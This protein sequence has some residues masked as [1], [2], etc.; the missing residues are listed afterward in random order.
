MVGLVV[1]LR[2]RIWSRLV[3]RNTGLLVATIMGV[4]FGLAMT[5]LAAGLLLALR[6]TALELRAAAVMAFAMLTFGWTALSVLSGAADSTV[7]P[8]RFALLPVRPRELARGLLAATLTGVP[9]A[10]LL[11][12]ALT[13]VITWSQSIGS[14]AAALVAA[15]LGVLT[16]VLLARVVSGALG[17]IMRSRR[18]RMA[19]ALAITVIAILPAMGGLYAGRPGATA[20]L[21]DID[22]LGIARTVGWTPLGW[23]WS[24]PLHVALGEPAMAVAAALLALTLIAGLWWLYVRL[25]AR[26]LT[27]PLTS[28]GSQRIR[29]RSL[30]VRWSR[31]GPVFAIAARRLVMW[32]RD[33]RLVTIAIQSTIM[34][35]ILVGQALVTGVPWTARF[36]LVMLAVFAGLHLLNDLAFDGTAWAMHVQTGTA[37]WEDRLG[38][39]L[40]AVITF[41]PGLAVLYAVLAVLDLIS[42]GGRWLA[43]VLVGFGA[44][45]G[46]ASVLGAVI[47]GN[48]PPPGGNPFAS[49]T[50]MGTQGVLSG[51]VALAVPLL[52]IAPVAVVGAVL[53]DTAA[54]TMALVAASAVGGGAFVLAG[55]VVGGQQLDRRAPELLDQLRRAD[56]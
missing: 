41:L 28:V 3:Q 33:S 50:G 46:S 11:V 31:H 40:A 4:L 54:A 2:W 48:A 29:G 10:L 24:L 17:A 53:P 42:G 22:A 45:V 16:T 13:S 55:V 21:G 36:A 38:R 9:P 18:G 39:V 52:C 43:Y 12:V 26:A 1:R 8:A 14:A 37:G 27:A 51:L 35:V 7:D 44:S 30:I 32:R 34:P 25:V 5:F 20:R 15:V 49:T 47:P 19:S 6:S 56:R 23:G